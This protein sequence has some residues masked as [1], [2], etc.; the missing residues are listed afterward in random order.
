M[1]KLRHKYD[2]YWLKCPSDQRK[3]AETAGFEWNRARCLWM[4]KNP[5]IARKLIQYAD[6][7][8]RRQITTAIAT[9][10]I[11]IAKSHA[12]D[13]DMDIPA[14]MGLAYRPYQKAGIAY[15]LARP[16]VLIADEMGLGK[17]IQ[18]VGVINADPSINTALVICP[19]SLKINW[20]R[21]L[22]KWLTRYYDIALVNSTDPWPETAEI[23]IINYDILHKYRPAIIARRWDALIVDECHYVKNPKAHRTQMIMGDHHTRQRAVSARRKI[24]L[25]GTPI[26]NRPIEGWAVFHFLAPTVFRNFWNYAKRYCAAYQGDWGW[27]MNGASNEAELQQKLRISIMVRR[28]K[29]QVLTEL[30][31][32]VRQIVELPANGFA[33][34]IKKE[35]EAL[36]KYIETDPA[37]NYAQFVK[38]A[39]ALMETRGMLL[40]DIARIRHEQALAKAPAVADF[41]LDALSTSPKVIVFAHHHDVI[42]CL[43]DRFSRAG[44]QNVV[45]TGRTPLKTRQAHVDLFQQNAGVRIFIGNIQAAGVGITLTAASHVV[46]AELDWVPGKVVQ[47]EDRAHRMGQKDSVLVQHLVVNG[48]IDVNLIQTLIQKQQI[49]DAVLDTAP[50]T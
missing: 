14:P 22:G 13:S 4:T 34:L 43:T 40:E 27:N 30:P 7:Q 18:A 32:K 6:E 50:A 21:E 3:L 35:V 26:E 44:I 47:A 24:F 10:T 11:A 12:V 16:N 19:A 38:E 36:R 31:P 8:T 2:C 25:G 39:Y 1:P 9:L 23:V 46:F 42:H 15:A 29:S 5:V 20:Q 37:K 28:L 33:R 48:S 41:V 17:T 45:V 49:L